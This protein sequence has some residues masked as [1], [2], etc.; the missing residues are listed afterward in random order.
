MRKF[1]P[2]VLTLRANEVSQPGMSGLSDKPA[3]PL[4]LPF[5][6]FNLVKLLTGYNQHARS[7]KKKTIM[8]ATGVR[9]QPL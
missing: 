7:Q 1:I 6:L 3:V 9:L 5:L 8:T 2:A 4:R